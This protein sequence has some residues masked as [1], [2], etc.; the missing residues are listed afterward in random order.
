MRAIRKI[1]V[2]GFLPTLRLALVALAG[3]AVA[4]YLIWY[5]GFGAVF[6]A[7]FTLGWAGFAILC[8]YALVLFC[9]LGAGWYVLVQDLPAQ[10]PAVFIWA[11]MVRDSAAE[12]LPFSQLGGFVIGARAAILQGVPTSIAAATMVV[13]ITTELAAQIAYVGLGIVLLS[14]RA[15]QAS[16]VPLTRGLEIG[17]LVA[18]LA[19]ALFFALQRYGHRFLQ[20]FASR[21]LPSA[22]DQATAI[23]AV[24]EKTYRAPGRVLVSFLLH[25]TG[26]VA[27]A[28]GT[29]IA[30]R[31]IGANLDL[32]TVVAIDSVVYA[33]RS[34]A[35]AIPNALGVQEAAYALLAPMLGVGPEIGLAISLIKRARDVA[36]GIP[37]LL[38]WQALEGNRALMAEQPDRNPL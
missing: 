3:T 7:V 1:T 2:T 27:S 17:V 6:S 8:G 18:A 37:T 33:I 5:V 14:L 32:G 12:T 10:R 22:F 28:V 20:N 15:P 9:V 29:W 4:A 19:S 26:W 36:I 21:F 16:A 24:L 34:V 35:F 13:D 23:S 30:F 31:L 25:L 38:I 11:R